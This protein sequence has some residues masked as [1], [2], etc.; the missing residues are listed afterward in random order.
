MG[1]LVVIGQADGPALP[2]LI[3]HAGERVAWR[4]LEFFTI[5]SAIKT[6]SAYSHAAGSFLRWCWDKGLMRIQQVQPVHVAAYVACGYLVHDPAPRR[7]CQARNFHRLPYFPRHRHYRYLAI[8]GKLKIA[9]RIA[10]HANAKT[11]SLLRSAQ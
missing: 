8:G 5:V 6:R 4:F 11:T 1:N 9:R 10:G 2:G 3:A 7:R